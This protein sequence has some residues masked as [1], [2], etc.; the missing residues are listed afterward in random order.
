M[1][2]ASRAGSVGGFGVDTLQGGRVESRVEARSRRVSD[3]QP[4]TPHVPPPSLWPIGFAIGVACILVGLVVSI[5]ALIVGAI[6]TLVFRPLWIPRPFVPR[7][8]PPRGAGRGIPPPLLPPPGAPRLLRPPPGGGREPG[9]S[10]GRSRT[11]RRR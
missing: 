8:P 11:V 9:C 1:A 7:P 3:E 10:L 4:D 5:P 6:I 2:A